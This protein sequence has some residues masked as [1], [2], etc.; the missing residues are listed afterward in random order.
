VTVTSYR[1]FDEAI[2]ALN[3][4]DYGLQGGV[5]TQDVNKVFHAFR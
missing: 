5:F 3:Q 2:R 1:Q 4:S